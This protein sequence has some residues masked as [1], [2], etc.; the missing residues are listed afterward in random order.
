MYS[1]SG[2][3]LQLKDLELLFG[4]VVSVA[5]GF[6]GIAVFVMLLIGGFNL[7]T[8]GSEAPKAEAAKKTITYAIFGMI[9]VVVSFLILR[10]IAAITGA[11]GILNFRVFQP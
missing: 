7:L 8:A 10:I 9:F 11:E 6:A 4:R 5:L 2:E 1:G 3:P